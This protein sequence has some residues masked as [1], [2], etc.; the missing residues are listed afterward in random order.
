M[1]GSASEIMRRSITCGSF[2]T[3]KR[4]A[5]AFPHLTNN[6]TALRFMTVLEYQEL[7]QYCISNSE[8]YSVDKCRLGL[9]GSMGPLGDIGK[10]IQQTVGT[11][12]KGVESAIDS[13]TQGVAKAT[14][15]GIA[16][17]KTT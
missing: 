14:S 13:V 10:S 12:Q 8:A 9:G 17:A 16:S 11:V 4:T 7:L 15:E 2:E 1:S 3:F 5:V 6:P